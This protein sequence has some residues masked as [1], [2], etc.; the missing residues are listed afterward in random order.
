MDYSLMVA[1]D[2]VTIPSLDECQ[3][4]LMWKD[5]QGACC[6]YYRCR[7]DI[8]LGKFYPFKDRRKM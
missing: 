7:S 1:V 4:L 5:S 8:H 2:E 6:G 3:K